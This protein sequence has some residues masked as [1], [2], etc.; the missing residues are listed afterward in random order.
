MLNNYICAV[1]I[2]SNKISAAVAVIRKRRIKNLFFETIASKG[3][4]RGAITDSVELI[5]CIERLLKGLKAK[6]GINIKVIYANICGQDI[7]TKH[8]HAILPLAERGNKVITLSDIQRVNNEARILGSSLE[9]EIIHQIPFSYS[10]DS[11][12][13][14]L[15]P[16]GLYSHRLEVDLYLVCAKMSSVQSLARVTSQAGYEIKDLFLSGIATSKIV[17]NKEIKEGTNV[18][19]DIGSDITELLIFREGLLKGIEIMPLGGNDLTLGIQEALKLSFELAED[20]KRTHCSIGDYNSIQEDKE[21]LI[22]KNNIYKPIK[23]K[24]LLEIL[25]SKAKFICQSIK[26]RLEKALPSNQVDNFVAL[27]KTVLLEGFLETLENTLGIP[28]KLGRISNPEIVQLINKDDALSG[29]KYLTY[30]TALGIISQV[31]QDENV[32]LSSANQP[33]SRNFFLKIIN[34]AKEVYEEYF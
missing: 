27:G 26:E 10:I 33:L 16:L 7:I 28:V 29:S 32:Y 24:L 19:C 1:D 5:G 17:F 25:T 18:L 6:S 22:K 34:R 11:K 30:I 3:I 31:L 15:Q 14:I 2:G 13:D 23:Q 4:K 9:E 8:S 21:I 20:V 12:S